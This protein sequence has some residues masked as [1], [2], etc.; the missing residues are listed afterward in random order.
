MKSRLTIPE[1]RPLVGSSVAVSQRQLRVRSVRQLVCA[2]L[3]C[4]LGL[5]TNSPAWA[6]CRQNACEDGI[7][8]SCTNFEDPD[9]CVETE[10][11]C[12]RDEDECINE[13]NTLH[14]LTSCMSF[15]VA[16]GNTAALGLTDEDLLD[17]VKE[18]FSRW[19]AVD[20][21]GGARPGFRIP[22]LGLVD[23]EEAYYCSE[24]ELNVSTWFLAKTWTHDQKALGFTFSTSSVSDG[25]VHDADVELNLGKIQLDFV[26][27]DWRK[28]L[29][30]IAT[31]EAGHF[32]GLAHSL[33]PDA[34]MFAAY[35]RKDLHERQLK[36][37]DF[38][39]I[40]AIFPPDPNLTCET[41]TL[42]EAGL[43]AEACLAAM[44]PLD[45]TDESSTSDTGADYVPDPLGERVRRRGCA[46][47]LSSQPSRLD[48]PLA[49]GLLAGAA[50]LLRR[51]RGA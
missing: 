34:V 18:A 17:V 25:V 15:A 31:H 38:E 42:V 14:R 16:R 11:L 22:N 51:R 20:C 43:S 36:Q 4:G 47:G 41:P 21:G 10:Y 7:R 13:G 50:L 45:T 5:L 1:L 29:L 3:T 6:F 30:S 27:S 19:Q 40:C 48:A 37:D 9:D 12:A 8:K 39:G 23:A 49:L 24:P 26:K 35:N 32:L 2:S 33:D 46:V 44:T 28:V